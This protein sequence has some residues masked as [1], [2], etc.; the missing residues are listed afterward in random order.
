M[1][2]LVHGERGFNILMVRSEAD[3]SV[4]TPNEFRLYSH[5]ARRAGAHGAWPSVASM[6]RQCRVH[7]DTIRRCLRRLMALNLIKA[8][9]RRGATTVYTLASLSEWIA[10]A[11]DGGSPPSHRKGHPPRGDGDGRT[12]SHGENAFN[13]LF[14][15]AELDDYVLIPSEF[16]L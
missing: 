14:I 6:A 12:L 7:E 16:R 15:R 9:P 10:E 11:W 1:R 8:C 3:D 2:D 5:L 4:L 13:I